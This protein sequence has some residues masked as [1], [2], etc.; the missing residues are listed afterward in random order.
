MTDEDKENLRIGRFRR[1]G[2]IHYWLYD[3]LSLGDL[4]KEAG[5]AGSQR[6]NPHTSQ[7][8]DWAQFHLDVKENGQAYD[9]HSLFI[10][11]VK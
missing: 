1:G 5:F 8:A 11:A 2:E 3:G 9:P 7:V 6:H 10:E 4:L